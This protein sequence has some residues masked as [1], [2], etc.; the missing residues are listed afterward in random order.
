MPGESTPVSLFEKLD[1]FRKIIVGILILGIGVAIAV[2]K[3]DIPPNLLQLLQVIFGGFIVGNVGEHI[4][5]TVSA[6]AGASVEVARI[7]ADSEPWD[8]EFQNVNIKMSNL[9]DMIAAHDVGATKKLTDIQNSLMSM[10]SVEPPKVV[11][12]APVTAAVAELKT[13]LT[14]PREGAPDYSA[15]VQA[16][17]NG[18]NE[19]QKNQA[20]SAR[21]LQTL[22]SKVLE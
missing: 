5:G 10:I 1:G 9:Q 20:I 12:L 19:I 13:L 14:T 7:Q 16:L 2:L 18:V 6:K 8:D 11:D 3:N 15:A 17:M 22:I 21:A 4:A